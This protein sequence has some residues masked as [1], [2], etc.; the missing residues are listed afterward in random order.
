[1]TASLGHYVVEPWGQSLPPVSAAQ[2]SRSGTPTASQ[3]LLTIFEAQRQRNYREFDRAQQQLITNHDH[4][5]ELFRSKL[6]LWL[7]HADRHRVDLRIEWDKLLSSFDDDFGEM[8]DASL[9]QEVADWTRK[10][11]A[12]VERF[13]TDCTRTLSEATQALDQT[14]GQKRTARAMKARWASSTFVPILRTQ[15]FEAAKHE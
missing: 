10:M 3:A 7:L 13:R 9:K 4:R 14:L 15:S 12:R 11:S 5:C 1:M 6:S 8:A 2:S